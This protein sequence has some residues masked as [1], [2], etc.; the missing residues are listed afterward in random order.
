MMTDWSRRFDEPIATPDDG[1][2]RRLLKPLPCGA[3]GQDCIAI[4]H[5]IPACRIDAVTLPPALLKAF[6]VNRMAATGVVNV[7]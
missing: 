2:L 3:P 4:A 6:I 1:E 7:A 5:P